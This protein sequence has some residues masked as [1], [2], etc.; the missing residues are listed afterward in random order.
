M[1][2]D[3][4]ASFLY[5]GILAALMASGGLFMF[6]SNARESL[7]MAGLWILIGAVVIV[8]YLAFKG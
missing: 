6:R 3:D 7:K 2:G 1:S 8:G 5:L 4:I